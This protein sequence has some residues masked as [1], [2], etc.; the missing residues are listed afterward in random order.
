MASNP[1]LYLWETYLPDF[2]AL[3]TGLLCDPDREIL[4]NDEWLLLDHEN[5][6]ELQLAYQI[7]HPHALTFATFLSSPLPTL[8]GKYILNLLYSATILLKEAERNVNI[9]QYDSIAF[10][11]P[12]NEDRK[13]TTGEENDISNRMSGKKK[14][15]W[16]S[17]P[18]LLSKTINGRRIVPVEIGK[19]Y[20]DPD[21]QQKIMTIKEYIHAHL[22]PPTSPNKVADNESGRF[23]YLAQHNLLT[24]IPSLRDDICIP[25][26][27]NYTQPTST[28]SHDNPDD[29]NDEDD[30]R[31]VETTINAWLGPADTITPLHTDNYH[32]IFC[33]IVGSKYVRLYPPS[34]KEAMAPMGKDEKGVDMANTSSLPVKWVENDTFI[35]SFSCTL[36]DGMETT[37]ADDGAVSDE[38]EEEKVR[39]KRFKEARYVEFVASEGDAIFFPKGW[40]HYVRSMEPSFSVNFW[41]T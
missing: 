8:S 10:D 4:V 28:P 26:Y 5:Y 36:G 19:T 11:I 25:E 27:I 38:E 24:Q 12:T 37:E 33:Q 9:L 17:I 6:H 29:Y 2:Q 32:N 14:N 18:Y 22:I 3:V 23:G 40:W 39:W 31:E 13:D 1:F 30:D 15:R 21:L 35:P 34:A 20:T 16:S 41:W 7:L